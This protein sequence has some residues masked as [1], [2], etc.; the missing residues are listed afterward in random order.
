MEVTELDPLEYP[1]LSRLGYVQ[2]MIVVAAVMAEDGE[3][4]LKIKSEDK[5]EREH[6]NENKLRSSS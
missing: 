6:K 4:G 3:L 1:I 2:R 5:H